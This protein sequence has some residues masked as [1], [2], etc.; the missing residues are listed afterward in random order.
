M[1]SKA[2]L[3]ALWAK[4]WLQ[5]ANMWCLTG[6]LGSPSYVRKLACKHLLIR[7][8]QV[9]LMGTVISS[10][11]VLRKWTFWPE[12]PWYMLCTLIALSR[13]HHVFSH[14]S[15]YS[16]SYSFHMNSQYTFCARAPPSCCLEA[17]HNAQAASEAQTLRWTTRFL[18]LAPVSLEKRREEHFDLQTAPVFTTVVGFISTN[19]PANTSNCTRDI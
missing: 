17:L 13:H 15:L 19:S 10:T 4:C 12:Q 6:A 16:V 3:V 11:N 9:R 1:Q 7:T 2:M 5:H 14:L 18:T 8:V